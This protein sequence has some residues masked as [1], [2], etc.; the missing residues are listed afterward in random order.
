MNCEY[1]LDIEADSL[2]EAE[3][4]ALKTDIDRCDEA[5]APLEIE[6]LEDDEEKGD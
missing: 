4:I 6:L 1:V 3:R 2:E 5:W